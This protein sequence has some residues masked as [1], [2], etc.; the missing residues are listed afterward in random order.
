M[1]RTLAALVLVACIAPAWAQ[2]LLPERRL[3]RDTAN[4]TDSRLMDQIVQI[5]EINPGIEPI[6]TPL[7]TVAPGAVAGTAALPSSAFIDQIIP[8]SLVTAASAGNLNLT[9]GASAGVSAGTAVGAATTV[10]PASIGVNGSAGVGVNAG[11]GANGGI[12]TGVLGAP[13]SPASIQLPA[14]VSEQLRT[15][16]NAAAGATLK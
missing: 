11:V 12:G 6:E 4:V 16:V 13:I 3:A 9:A 14:G 2:P 5:P 7:V 1:K 10:G 8:P 15:Q